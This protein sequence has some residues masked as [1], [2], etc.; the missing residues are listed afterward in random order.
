MK[1]VYKKKRNKKRN[2]MCDINLFR[3]YYIISARSMCCFFSL[4]CQISASD[5]IQCYCTKCVCLSACECL[6]KYVSIHLLHT[7]LK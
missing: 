5:L 7:F 4:K 1:K 2:E 6:Q 3:S